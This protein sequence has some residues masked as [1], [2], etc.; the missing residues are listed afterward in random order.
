MDIPCHAAML[1][2]WLGDNRHR[3]NSGA[4]RLETVMRSFKLVT[5]KVNV[6]L[7]MFGLAAILHAVL[8]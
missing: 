2:A 1:Q 7:C 8:K 4:V 6:A 3:D 5:V